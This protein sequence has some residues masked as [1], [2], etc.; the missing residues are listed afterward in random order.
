MH[1]YMQY[2]LIQSTIPHRR[3][4]DG[5]TPCHAAVLGGRPPKF[6]DK[7]ISTRNPVTG[8]GC[9]AVGC[10]NLLAYHLHDAKTQCKCLQQLVK[11][12]G[13]LKLQSVTNETA[14]DVAVRMRKMDVLELIEHYCEC[15]HYIVSVV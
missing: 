2:N 7:T 14:R 5:Q 12:G 11:F 9:V 13:D 4:I 15:I 3:N 8:A 1:A 10:Y 6:P